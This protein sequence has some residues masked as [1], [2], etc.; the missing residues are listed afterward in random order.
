MRLWLKVLIL[1]FIL[2]LGFLL[3]TACRLLAGIKLYTLFSLHLSRYESFCV[4][5]I[6]GLPAKVILD[7]H[8]GVSGHLD[9]HFGVYLMTSIFLVTVFPFYFQYSSLVI[10]L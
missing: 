2:V 5:K 7:L 6:L 4:D 1:G 9:L 3:F 10:C 8:F